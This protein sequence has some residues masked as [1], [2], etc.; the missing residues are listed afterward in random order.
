VPR[1]HISMRKIRDVLRLKFG[2]ELSLRQV[3]ASLGI[4][5]TTVSGYV[6]RA[7]AAGLGWPLPDDL[8]DDALEALL[9]TS[10]RAPSAHRQLPDFQKIHLELR[11]PH[12]TLMLLW[13]EYKETFPDGYAYSQFALLYRRWHRHLDVVMRQAHKAGEKLFVDFPGAQI[14]IYDRRSGEVAFS[15]ELFVAVLGASSYI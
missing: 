10:G 13:H 5:F 4:P 11:R 15:A 1:P 12:V 9:F 7:Q 8:D 6:K 2:G 3:S 14:P